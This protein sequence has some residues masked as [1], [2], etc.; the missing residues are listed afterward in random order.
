MFETLAAVFIFDVTFIIKVGK[1]IREI[2]WMKK[3]QSISHT[4]IIQ[5]SSSRTELSAIT[6]LNY[7][8]L[9]LLRSAENPDNF[10][11][12]RNCSKHCRASQSATVGRKLY[13]YLLSTLVYC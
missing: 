3:E 9:Q 6:Y 8:T 11:G 4:R 13:T 1:H 5:S 7:V 10:C 2:L 12:K